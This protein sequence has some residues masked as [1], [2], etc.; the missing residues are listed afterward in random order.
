ML[1]LLWCITALVGGDHRTPS[2]EKLRLE[3]EA[4]D[5]QRVDETVVK[6]AIEW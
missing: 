2:R 6:V 3:S 1:N 5:A 4:S